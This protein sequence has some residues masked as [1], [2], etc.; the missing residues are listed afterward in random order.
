MNLR[1]RYF[2]YQQKRICRY[3]PQMILGAIVLAVFAGTVAFCAVSKFTDTAEALKVPV[4][5]VIESDTDTMQLA[6]N[7][8]S[9]MES[10][11][12]HF[13]F[14]PMNEQDAR[15]ALKNGKVCA[16]MLLPENVLEGIMDGTNYHI[17]VLLSDSDVLSAVLLQELA[18][19]GAKTL[20][21]AQAGTYTMTELYRNAG[22]SS[23]LNDAYMELDIRN[24][25]YALVRDDLF[26]INQA[27]PT[28]NVSLKN[29]Y[30][31]S[32]VLFYLLLSGVCYAGFYH[33]GSKAQIQKLSSA[34]IGLVTQGISQ[35]C[36]ILI[37]QLTAAFPLFL[38]LT[39]WNITNHISATTFWKILFLALLLLLSSTAYLLLIMS[40]SKSS[41][42]AVI[43]I[44]TLSVLLMFISGCFIP[45]GLL[46]ESLLRI[47]TFLPTTAMMQQL[48]HMMSFSDRTTY[49]YVR[50]F[51]NTCIILLCDALV[52]LLLSFASLYFRRKQ[53]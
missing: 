18:I 53:P 24:L 6:L 27:S 48:F 20:S 17:P 14:Q 23:A 32:G 41:G 45:I 37:S 4:A 21:A 33:R 30:L 34:R 31:S 28:G 22:L 2:L 49:Q 47:R 1:F 25:Q 52:L 13:V 10:V 36:S 42:M 40:C 5:L 9:R 39:W 15:V 16:V 51:D 29:Y 44:F 19:S 50:L 11:E 46:P 8:I 3:I 26:H 7:I 38:F 43:L 35:F 12:E